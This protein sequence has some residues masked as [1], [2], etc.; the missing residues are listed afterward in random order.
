MRITLSTSVYTT[1]RRINVSSTFHPPF[2]LPSFFP[3]PSFS[4]FSFSP[5][6]TRIPRFISPRDSPLL[7]PDPPFFLSPCPL[8]PPRS[9][10]VDHRPRFRFRSRRGRKGCVPR[11]VSRATSR[12]R[13]V[14]LFHSSGRGDSRCGYTRSGGRLYKGGE[15]FN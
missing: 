4:P 10:P 1:L 11:F 14:F 3:S 7:S 6:V 8:P 2:F 13:A 12:K 15:C 9:P 5:F